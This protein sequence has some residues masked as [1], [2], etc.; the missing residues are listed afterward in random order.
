MIF[1]SP[2]SIPPATCVPRSWKPCSN[3]R[4]KSPKRIWWKERL[5]IVKQAVNGEA[6]KSPFEFV[7]AIQSAQEAVSWSVVI[8]NLSCFT[9][10]RKRVKPTNSSPA[11]W[12]GSIRPAVLAIAH[13]PNVMQTLLLVCLTIGVCAIWQ[14]PRSRFRWTL[15]Q[16]RTKS[17]D[18]IQK[19]RPK[20]IWTWS[21]RHESHTQ[22]YGR[23]FE[24]KGMD[25]RDLCGIYSTSMIETDI[26]AHYLHSNSIRATAEHFGMGKS[27]GL[28]IVKRYSRGV[29]P[30]LNRTNWRWNLAPIHF[31]PLGPK[32]WLHAAWCSTL[33][34]LGQQ[35]VGDTDDRR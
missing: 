20:G 28:R 7:K 23:G 21:A 29:R 26:V 35:T 12:T 22:D 30:I 16:L 4:R 14:S 11:S 25:W 8:D 31:E 34:C 5:H 33:E 15:R 24:V 10:M 1:T 2:T 9:W 3:H 13:T 19:W 17:F 18:W 32:F 27:Q 6:M